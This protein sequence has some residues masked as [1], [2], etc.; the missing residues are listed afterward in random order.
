MD[1][2]GG[3]YPGLRHSTMQMQE[4]HHRTL[5]RM[6]GSR[7]HPDRIDSMEPCHRCSIT[8]NAVKS[9]DV[10]CTGRNQW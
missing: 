10:A 4:A 2:Q 7:M 9:V 5:C 8:K 6:V 3:G 1:M